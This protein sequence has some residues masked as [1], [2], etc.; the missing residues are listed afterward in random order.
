MLVFNTL[1]MLGLAFTLNLLLP[2][3]AMYTFHDIYFRR[4]ELDSAK[5]SLISIHSIE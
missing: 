2:S 5:L 1:N 3:N 4:D